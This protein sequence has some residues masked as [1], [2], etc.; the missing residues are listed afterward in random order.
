MNTP[1]L[2]ISTV[3]LW[4][5]T[6]IAIAAQVG[7]APVAVSV[8][9]RFALAAVLMLAALF[10]LGKLE[11]PKAWRFVFAQALCLFCFNF[12]GIYNAT[13]PLQIGRAHV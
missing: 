8:F 10:A 6:W 2:F 3:V 5:T 11:R 12:I 1:V 7:E 9:Y 4:G 13:T